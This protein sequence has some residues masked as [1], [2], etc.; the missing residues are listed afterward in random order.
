MSHLLHSTP[1]TI[2]AINPDQCHMPSGDLY[3]YSPHL[4]LTLSLVL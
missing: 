3:E 4:T 2:N 1:S